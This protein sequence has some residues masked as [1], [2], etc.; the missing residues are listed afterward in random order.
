LILELAER[1]KVQMG[2]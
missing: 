1:L 2:V